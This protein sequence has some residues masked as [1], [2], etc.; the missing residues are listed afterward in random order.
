MANNIKGMVEKRNALYDELNALL[1]GIEQGDEVRA[2]SEDERREFDEKSEQI[3]ALDESIR[4]IET[5]NRMQRY[6]ADGRSDKEARS[7]EE[8]RVLDE[9]DIR[10]YLNGDTRALPVAD[11]G[12][13]I[14]STIANRIIEEVK[15][16]CPIYNLVD[17]YHA[18]G[19]LVFPV[20]DESSA[21]IS[22]AYV[23]DLA[24]LTEGSG[25]F[26]T[27]TLKNFIMGSLVKISKSLLNQTDFDIVSFVTKK[28]AK[29]IADKIGREC[30]LGTE[31]KM[32][33]LMETTNLVTAAATAAITADEL[34]DVQMAVPE[35]YQSDACWIMN[36]STFAALRKLKDN[37][38]NYLLNKDLTTEFRWHL[39]GKRVYIDSNVP[40]I[41]AGKKV[42][43][44]GDMKGL[45]LK[46]TKQIEMQLLQEK[47]AT[48]HAVGICAYVEC[49]SKIIDKQRFVV[50]QMKAG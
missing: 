12:G 15:E 39:L 18:K 32:Q 17:V 7:L 5:A 34:I 48:Q 36:K 6:E 26:T 13:I 49:D 4:A 50:L 33:G 25:K 29:A 21:Q 2:L 20:Y 44:Y 35:I 42:L 31:N 19:D 30:L 27:I 23:D 47:Y 10:A 9:K 38:G 24:E 3:K 1:N 45:A 43:V 22:A 46:H 28:V 14:P 8:Q 37:D 16:L 40:E 41:G 11:N